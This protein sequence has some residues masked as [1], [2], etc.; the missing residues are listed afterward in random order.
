MLF[1]SLPEAESLWRAGQRLPAIQAAVAAINTLGP[2]KPAPRVLQLGYYLYLINDFAGAATVL[3]QLVRQQPD[4]V[5][6]LMNLAVCRQRLQQHGQVLALA[7]RALALQPGAPL[8]LDLRTKSLYRLGREDEARAAGAASLH[9]KDAALPEPARPWVP[10]DARPD[11]VC[12]GKT[13]VI[14]FS[15]WGANPRY[16]RGALRNALLVADLYPGWVMRLYCD[17]TVPEP[18]LAALRTLQVD[19]RLQPPGQSLRQRLCWRFA[20]A[21]DP[22]VGRFLVRDCDSVFSLRECAAVD[23]WRASGRWFHVI[24]DW[25]THTDLMLA[26][27]WGGVAGG[28]PDLGA[29]LATYQSGRAETPNIDQWFLRDRVWP[30]VRHHVLVHD[31]CFDVPGR[32]PLPA[33]AGNVHIGQDEH[34]AHPQRQRLLLAA[35]IAQLPCLQ[36]AED[37]T[38]TAGARPA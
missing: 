4:H 1:R 32:R 30:L 31:R 14:A 13:D 28:L 16:L 35:W 34:A 23:E 9:A 37:P 6:G 36:G 20:V 26:G 38:P 25:W 3:E 22:L 7:D 12:A 17:A 8:A 24:R 10:P 29:L 33:P 5:E 2:D 19:V 18:F 27:L 15:L 11:E 21:N